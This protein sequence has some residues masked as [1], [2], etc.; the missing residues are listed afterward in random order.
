MIPGLI[1][2]ALSALNADTA[3]A[4]FLIETALKTTV[5]LILVSLPLLGYRRLTAGVR[6]LVL[7]TAVLM[8]LVVP[9]PSLLCTRPGTSSPASDRTVQKISAA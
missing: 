7:L 5:P 2:E 8:A 3:W 4:Q 1:S 6:H 9:V